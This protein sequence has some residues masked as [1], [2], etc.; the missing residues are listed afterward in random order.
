MSIRQNSVPPRLTTASLSLDGLQRLDE[1]SSNVFYIL[2]DVGSVV[3]EIH[4]HYEVTPVNEA[5]HAVAYSLAGRAVQAI[6]IS[7]F[8]NVRRG[9]G[10]ECRLY[11][12]MGE[13]SLDSAIAI[14]GLDAV[15]RDI[16]GTYAGGVAELRYDAR[17]AHSGRKTD[18]QIAEQICKALDYAGHT[19]RFE[20]QRWAWRE[21]CRMFSDPAVWAATVEI[22]DRLKSSRALTVAS[23]TGG[24]VRK[25]IARHLPDGWEWSEPPLGQ[26]LEAA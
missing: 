13:R 17:R 18:A 5:G 10:G 26:T 22:A 7:I 24:V 19:E 14:Y 8:R 6:K 12:P 16:V 2:E 15:F 20:C 3:C 21:T 11:G 1:A 25:I 9:L 23:V 4:H